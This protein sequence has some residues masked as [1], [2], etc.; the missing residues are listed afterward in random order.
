MMGGIRG[1]IKLPYFTVMF[2]SLQLRGKF[3][4]ERSDIRDLI[5]VVEMGILKLGQEAGHESIQFELEGWE[6]AMTAAEERQGYGM[7]VLMSPQSKTAV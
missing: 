4:Y 3:M 7:V 5:K 2:K 1:D 6:E